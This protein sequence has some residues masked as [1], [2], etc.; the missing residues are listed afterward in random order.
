M[1][2]DDGTHPAARTGEEHEP[3]GPDLCHLVHD[4]NGALGAITLDLF[5]FRLA[6]LEVLRQTPG[7]PAD[8]VSAVEQLHEELAIAAGRARSLAA[9]ITASVR[10]GARRRGER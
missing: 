10:D 4:L 8:G 2:D 3:A 5:T 7:A 6:W 1:L 9:R